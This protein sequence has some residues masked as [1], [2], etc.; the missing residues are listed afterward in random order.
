M[1]HRIFSAVLGTAIAMFASQCAQAEV[2]VTISKMHLCCG[3]CVKAV[4]GALE[5]V[6]G[7]SVKVDKDAGSAVVTAP[8][9]KTARRALGA[10]GRAGFHGETDNEKL[11]MPDNSGVKKG[12]VKRLELVGVHN[13]C[14][15]CNKAIKEA[16]AT[17]DGVTADTAE[18]KKNTLV[19]EGNFDGLALIAALNKAGFHVRDKEAAKE[20][21]AAR[22]KKADEAK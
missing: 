20:A 22:K 2:S 11:K 14:G 17:V 5:K 15:G 7:A 8:D 12:M 16:I 21:A 4:E 10:I 1:T 18:A 19:V 9:Q 13:C 3:A 6:E